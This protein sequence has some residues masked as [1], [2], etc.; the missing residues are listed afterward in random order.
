MVEHL[1][2]VPLVGE[3]HILHGD[4]TPDVFQLH[5]VGLVLQI[6]F[7]AHQLNKAVEAG[8]AV[9]KELVE[10]SHLPHGIDEG[11]DVEVKRN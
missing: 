7:N 6:R 8:K 9:G 11:A 2:V 4:L 10:I 5:R 1:R 3:A